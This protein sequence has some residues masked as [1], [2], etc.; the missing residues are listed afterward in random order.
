M[1][2]DLTFAFK[3]FDLNPEE[4]EGVDMSFEDI[5]QS[6]E[7]C[8]LSLMGKVIG[9]KVT[10]FTG[11]KN[12][13][14]HVW[15]YPKNLKVTELKANLFWFHFESEQE[16]EKALYGGPWVIDNQL[17]V[18]KKWEAGIE[19][20]MEVFNRAYLWV[21]IWNLPIHW[22]SKAVGFKIGDVFKYVREVIIL[23]SGGKA[24][25]H[26][27][28]LA[29]IDIAKPLARGTRVKLNGVQCGIIGHGDKNCNNEGLNQY[30]L[31]EDQYGAWMKAGNIMASPLRTRTMEPR[32]RIHVSGTQLIRG[33]KETRA[34]EGNNDTEENSKEGNQVAVIP[35]L[36]RGKP[37]PVDTCGVRSA[38]TKATEKEG[39]K[40]KEGQMETRKD[41]EKQEGVGD[42][43]KID[44]ESQGQHEGKGLERTEEIV[45]DVTV[46]DV[47]ASLE[48]KKERVGNQK[49]MENVG[50]KENM[51]MQEQVIKG[52][53][54]P[55]QRKF[56]RRTRALLG[57]I[58]NTPVVKMQGGKG[59]PVSG[60]KM[61]K[62]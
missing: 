36:G 1:A 17:L 39:K 33:N 59:K 23:S 25:R 47:T 46:M 18:I 32:E 7:E 30:N 6:V 51:G 34:K 11:I 55:K 62:C 24:R 21:Q 52:G 53:H 2:D 4:E 20:K 54:E 60:M 15:G 40:Y 28:I 41:S 29:E 19:R 14:A 48:G 45:M 5:Q 61:L 16:M 3:R 49:M 37:E 13:T 12:F 35:T 22:M 38:D 44:P 27:K 10:N 8:Q 58:N 26:M 50:N 31:R 43:F 42:K 9:E 56:T 57:S